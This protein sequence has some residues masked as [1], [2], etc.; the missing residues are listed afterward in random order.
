VPC[1]AA[2]T[3]RKVLNARDGPSRFRRRIEV[4]RDTLHRTRNAWQ[5]NQAVAVRSQFCG[6]LRSRMGGLVTLCK[7]VD[8]AHPF[9]TGTEPREVG[10][11]SREAETRE[12][13]TDCLA[14]GRDAPMLPPGTDSSVFFDV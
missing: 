8:R 9:P 13:Q 11:L 4:N 3:A 1:A 6:G 7:E 14:A 12:G 5:V 2:T 10:E